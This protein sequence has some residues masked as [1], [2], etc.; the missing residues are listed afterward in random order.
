MKTNIV[1]ITERRE[2]GYRHGRL[3]SWMVAI[4]TDDTGTEYTL[5]FPPDATENDFR[6]TWQRET[7]WK[8]I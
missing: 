8:I 6:E 5:S 2:A 4:I 3:V 1:A 7:C